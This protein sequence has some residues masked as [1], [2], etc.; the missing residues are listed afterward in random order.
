MCFLLLS[1]RP[2]LVCFSKPGQ[3]LSFVPITVA[4]TRFED[5]FEETQIWAGSGYT[6]VRFRARPSTFSPVNCDNCLVGFAQ[7]CQEQVQMPEKGGANAS[8]LGHP[9][10]LQV[11]SGIS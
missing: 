5:G 7:H 3:L 11:C 4:L 1:D 8:C 9:D 2:F 10:R 6:S